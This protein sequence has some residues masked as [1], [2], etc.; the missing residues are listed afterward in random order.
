MM[1]RLK[2]ILS[3]LLALVVC[4]ASSQAA[5][6]ELSCGLDARGMACHMAPPSQ[7]A[8]MEMQHGHCSPEMQM[9]SNTDSGIQI[10]SMHSAACGHTFSPA[11]ENQFAAKARFG[12]SAI[13]FF[14]DAS[15]E[16]AMPRITTFSEQR[17]PP[18]VAAASS[19]LI[20]LR[21]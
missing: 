11:V 6:C 2:P 9:S 5:V 15:T 19:L 12:L 8:S 1:S 18:R 14:S 16:H 13:S 21:V 7:Q 17:P 4:G 20:T 10:G 3:V